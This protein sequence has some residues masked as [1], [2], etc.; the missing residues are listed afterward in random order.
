M[1]FKLCSWS[2]NSWILFSSLIGSHIENLN[3]FISRAELEGIKC[4]SFLFMKVKRYSL[5]F[6]SSS[7]A[8][9]NEGRSANWIQPSSLNWYLLC[10]KSPNHWCW[11]QRTVRLLVVLSFMR[12]KKKL[13]DLKK[14]WELITHN[15][16]SNCISFIGRKHAGD[17]KRSHLPIT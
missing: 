7:I 13:H 1:F 6:K 5:E 9:Y 15:L 2:C 10:E 4:R 8:L 14:K 17:T 3:C 11:Y 16:I 12:C